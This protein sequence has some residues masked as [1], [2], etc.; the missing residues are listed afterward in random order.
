MAGR[1]RP[2][3]IGARPEQ[4]GM[5]DDID[6]LQHAHHDD[7]R[8][9]RYEC[10]TLDKRVAVLETRIDA[11]EHAVSKIEVQMKELNVAL[12]ESGAHVTLALNSLGQKFDAHVVQE[13]KDRIRLLTWMIT[14][15]LA[16]AA[17][18]LAWGAPWIWTH[19]TSGGV[20]P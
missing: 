8:L 15:F 19:L 12:R 20:G 5:T 13:D 18:L 4:A 2:A 17:S 3:A 1:R 14:T 7:M 6:H 11:S 10:A 16:V 9:I